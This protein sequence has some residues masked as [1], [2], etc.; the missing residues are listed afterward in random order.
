MS[1]PQSQSPDLSSDENGF[2]HADDLHESAFASRSCC[3]WLPCLR[4]N[5]SQAGSMWWERIRTSEHDDDWWLRGWRRIRG[6]SEIVAGPKWKTF[7]RQFNKSPRNRQST[8]RYDPLSYSLNF[9][10][11]PVR[12]DPFYEDHKRRDFST[13]F[14]AM[15][16]SAKSSM[17]LG[18]DG[19]SFI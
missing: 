1:V 5:P 17:D 7:I 8:F 18:K 9:D 15:P 12:D 16:S 3:L 11:G 6:W 10:E 14:A 2:H 13:R 4:S 19:L